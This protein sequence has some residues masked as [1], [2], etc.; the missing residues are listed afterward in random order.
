MGG[1]GSVLRRVIRD[2]VGEGK[3]EV[4]GKGSGEFGLR[5]IT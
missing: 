5:D 4:G 1:E 2:L 3:N